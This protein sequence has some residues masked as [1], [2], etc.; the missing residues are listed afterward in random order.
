MGEV[1]KINFAV[2]RRK[3]GCIVIDGHSIQYDRIAAGTGSRVEIVKRQAVIPGDRKLL[4][5]G[6]HTHATHNTINDPTTDLYNRRGYRGKGYAG[7]IDPEGFQDAQLSNGQYPDITIIA[8]YSGHLFCKP[9]I[10]QDA[11]T[12]GYHIAEPAIQVHI[13]HAVKK[14]V[15]VGKRKHIV[16]IAAVGHRDNNRR[17]RNRTRTVGLQVAASGHYIIRSIPYICTIGIEQ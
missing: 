1:G 9:G 17:L 10:H 11:F 3:A 16:F 2:I 15:I 5:V 13:D 8:R 6:R 12:A 7:I 14:A 4:P